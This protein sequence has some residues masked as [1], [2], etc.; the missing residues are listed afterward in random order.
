MFG[1]LLV[2]Y[3]IVRSP[4][5]DEAVAIAVSHDMRTWQRFGDRPVRVVTAKRGGLAER[6]SRHV[7]DRRLP[8]RI[9]VYIMRLLDESERDCFI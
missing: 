7:G 4:C 5:G 9:R 3:C 6:R 1:L 8:A 2:L